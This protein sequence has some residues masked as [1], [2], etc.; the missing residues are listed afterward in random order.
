MLS[1]TVY[2][3]SWITSFGWPDDDSLESK[4]VAV[5]ISL[6]NKIVVFD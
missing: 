6:C 2:D 1:N 3:I 4:H 5:S